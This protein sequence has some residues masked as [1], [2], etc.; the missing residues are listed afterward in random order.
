MSRYTRRQLVQ[1][2]GAVGLGLLAGCGRLP[3]QASPARLPRIGILSS[4]QGPTAAALVA[5]QEGLREVG[6]IE[7]QTL[8]IEWRKSAEPDFGDLDALAAELVGLQ[9]SLILAVA[10][11]AALAAKRVTSTTPIV[12]TSVS[13][14][15]GS[16]LATSLGRPGSNA[17]GLSDFGATLSGKR[18]E[19]LRDAVPGT[20]RVGM[21]WLS[22]NPA[23]ALLW[24]ETNA[25]APSLGV[26]LIPLELG[27]EDALEDTFEAAVQERVD[28]VIV[29]SSPAIAA[30]A[31]VLAFERRLPTMLEQASAVP[32]G[33]LLAYGP[34]S[35]E[36]YRRAA[37]YVDKI[38]KG[39]TP[40]ELPIEQPTVFDFVINLKT[41]QALGLT[42][43]H[44]VLLQATELI[45]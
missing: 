8:A 37:V 12:F 9:V 3:G 38:L 22:R 33:G 45:Q 1:G 20:S 44:H 42:I 25:V 4:T 32:E 21:V 29:L 2:A 11:P 10:T 40:A 13:D 5:L 18:L 36:A 15:I 16:G 30:R 6:Y 7:G 26:K 14:P 19:L 17:T 31:A 39:A 23:N 24:R 35:P 41:A 27:G 34:R 43:P 28:S